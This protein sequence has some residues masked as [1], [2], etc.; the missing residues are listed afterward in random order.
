MSV[1]QKVYNTLNVSALLTVA[2]GGV[3]AAGSLTGPAPVRP[4]VI[5]RVQDETPGLRGD[6]DVPA[7]T[8]NVQIWVYDD[9]GTFTRI[10]AALEIVEELMRSASGLRCT[11]QGRSGELPD[12]EQKA[13]TKNVSYG[14]GEIL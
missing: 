8:T 13:I 14:V 11:W 5:Y 1:R 2:P 6:D 9:P 10:E 12:D 7:K 4:F 3:K